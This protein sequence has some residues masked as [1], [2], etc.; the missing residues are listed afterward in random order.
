MLTD[1]RTFALSLACLAASPALASQEYQSFS[2]RVRWRGIGGEGKADILFDDPFERGAP[3]AVRQPYASW[4]LDGS[5]PRVSQLLSLIGFAEAG[6]LQYDAV[7][8]SASRR[9]P[10]RPTQL[11]IGQIEHW[12]RATPGQH[13]AIG[14]YQFIP[15]T[16][17]SLKRRAGLSTAAVFSHSVQ[18]GLA[19]L[20]LVDAGL[21]RLEAGEIRMSQFMDNLA[22]IWAGLPTRTGRSAYHGYAGNRATI[23][24]DFYARQ[25]AA[26]F[27]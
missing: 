17:V 25:M 2:K 9:P 8:M 7:H 13:H 16:L 24:R 20:L 23:S 22:K 19:Y 21:K 5:A 4:Q 11:S 10:K 1:R 14:R 3:G 15:S 12:I 26:I 18:D 27:S 6:R